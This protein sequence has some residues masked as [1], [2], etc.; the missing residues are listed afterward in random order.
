MGRNEGKIHLIST[1]LQSPAFYCIFTFPLKYFNCQWRKEG[2]S[3]EGAVICPPVAS[4]FLPQGEA[5]QRPAQES[6]PCSKLNCPSFPP[7][8]SEGP[9]EVGTNLYHTQ[10]RHQPRRTA[11]KRQIPHV[12]GRRGLRM[13]QHSTWDNRPRVLP[14]KRY[15][16]KE[17]STLIITSSILC[18]WWIFIHSARCFLGSNYVCQTLY[19]TQTSRRHL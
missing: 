15:S 5:E 4:W 2:L 19:Q 7:L 9:K 10:D 18:D 13:Q 14:R 17:E 12:E 16:S 11:W 3:L 6:P 8:N 1:L